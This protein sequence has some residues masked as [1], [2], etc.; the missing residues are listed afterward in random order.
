MESV[1]TSFHI[2]V[3]ILN[4][5]RSSSGFIM[6]TGRWVLITLGSSML[7][8]RVRGSVMNRG[9]AFCISSSSLVA[10]S[11][12]KVGVMVPNSM[13]GLLY[14]RGTFLANSV[15]TPLVICQIISWAHCKEHNI[16]VKHQK[17]YSIT[18]TV[19]PHLG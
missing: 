7:L 11:L 8:M 5:A 4:E 10:L 6:V 2:I 14:S 3:N 18:I 1:T 19:V 16:I 13:K 12:V 17:M 15:S 9:D